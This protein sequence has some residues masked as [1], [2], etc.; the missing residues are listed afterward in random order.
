MDTVDLV[1]KSAT[2][3]YNEL[4]ADSNGR[5]RSWEHCYK[6]FH[7][8]RDQENADTDSLSLHLAFYLASWGMYR[9]SSFLLQKDYKIHIPI[10]E[11]LLRKEYDVL[12]GIEC[13]KYKDDT[14]CLLLQELSAKIDDYY[15]DIRRSVKGSGVAKHISDTLITKIH[16][17]AFASAECHTH[18]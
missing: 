17:A 4:K 8:A 5:Y 16:E 1:I 14:V 2:I 3:F 15:A 7:D 6:C 10:I 11:E 12:F 18:R 9:G 13:A